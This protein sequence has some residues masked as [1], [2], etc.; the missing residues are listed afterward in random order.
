VLFFDTYHVAVPPRPCLK[1]RQPEFRRAQ[2][3]VTRQ[4]C[5]AS[6]P[7]VRDALGEDK[8]IDVL[9]CP[10]GLRIR[11]SLEVVAALLVTPRKQ[12][13]VPLVCRLG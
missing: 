8:V 10:V 3:L 1:P 7:D 9:S 6:E 11:Q 5:P 2:W 13:E 4:G 12:E